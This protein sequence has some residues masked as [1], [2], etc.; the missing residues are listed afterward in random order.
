[1]TSAK[2][3][4]KMIQT[5]IDKFAHICPECRGDAKKYYGSKLDEVSSLEKKCEA[6]DAAYKDVQKDMDD[7]IKEV[8][9]AWKGTKC[10]KEMPMSCKMSSGCKHFPKRACAPKTCYP[11]NLLKSM[12]KNN[13][14]KEA[15]IECDG[16]EKISLKEKK[17]EAYKQMIQARIA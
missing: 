4:K 11:I 9:G 10:P 13:H 5:I 6:D 17:A 2:D 12:A 3:Q 1:M 16:K 14:C 15:T 7:L 8:D